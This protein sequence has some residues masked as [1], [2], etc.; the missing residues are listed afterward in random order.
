MVAQLF[1]TK[2]EFLNWYFNTG[3]DDEQ[4]STKLEYG[5]SLIKSLLDENE[6]IITTKDLFEDGYVEKSCIPCKY[7]T[8]PRDKN[9]LNYYDERREEIYNRSEQGE[10]LMDLSFDYELKL[11][12]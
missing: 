2:K 8:F 9:S 4:E 11:A 7:V 1:I 6:Y 12:D 5:E 10:E 3:S